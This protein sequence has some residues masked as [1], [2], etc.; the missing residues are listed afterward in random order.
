MFGWIEYLQLKNIKEKQV[1]VEN[2]IY[3][4]NYVKYISLED[5]HTAY[6]KSNENF[7]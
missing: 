1:K 6:I 7:N 4:D 2:P 3:V 5:S